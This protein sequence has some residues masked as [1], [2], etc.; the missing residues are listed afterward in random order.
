MN[1]KLITIVTVPQTKRVK[2]QHE[3]CGRHVYSKIHVVRINDEIT[4]VG[5]VCFRKL[6]GELDLKPT[7]GGSIG[8]K[9]TESEREL[10]LQNTEIFLNELQSR[11]DIE[12]PDQL[13]EADFQPE[14][15]K[16]EIT[17]KRGKPTH[18]H[19]FRCL[20][21]SNTL[22]N[23]EFESTERLCPRCNTSEMVFTI[24]KYPV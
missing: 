4:F 3:G 19:L 1:V 6:F 5:S 14:P 8:T 17:P 20:S 7:F 12:E 24:E 2:C 9:L 23:Y 18:I 11:Y 22:S 13:E 21:C 15:I 16:S 10:I